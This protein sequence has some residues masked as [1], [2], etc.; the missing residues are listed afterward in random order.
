MKELTRNLRRQKRKNVIALEEYLQNNSTI[1]GYNVLISKT[2]ALDSD[3][4]KD[5]ADRLADKLGNA[6]VF[7]RMCWLTESF[8]LQNKIEN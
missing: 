2:Q 4:L 8:C 1:K 3:V 6:V 5:L 7:L